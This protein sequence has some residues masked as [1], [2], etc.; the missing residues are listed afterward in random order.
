M[1]NKRI[2]RDDLLKIEV[3]THYQQHHSL[4]FN[5]HSS[6]LVLRHLHPGASTLGVKS[7]A[8][9]VTLVLLAAIALLVVVVAVDPQLVE[10]AATI[11]HAAKTTAVSV[12]TTIAAAAALLDGTAI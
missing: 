9:D 12:T 2:G 5:I 6:G 8:V 3:S 11:L 10:A 7:H 4:V 1:H